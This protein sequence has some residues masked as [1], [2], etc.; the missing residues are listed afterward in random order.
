MKVAFIL[1]VV[2][3]A[4]MGC[5][6]LSVDPLDGDA[7]SEDDTST[8]PHE[9]SGELMLF[10]NARLSDASA[11]WGAHEP[12]DAPGT[13]VGNALYLYDPDRICDDGTNACRVVELGNL[14]LDGTLGAESVRDGSLRKLVIKD[15]AWHAELGLWGVTYDPLN[16]E[17]G[18]G[19]LDVPAWDMPEQLI[20][21][22]RY[23]IPQGAPEHPD[24]DPCYW[25]EA[26]T[27][28]GFVE[29]TLLLG[30]RGAGGKGLDANGRLFR[31]DFD[32]LLEHGNCVDENDPSQDPDYY[33]CVNLCEAWCDFGEK[34][35]VAGDVEVSRDGMRA[36]AWVRS[37]DGDVMEL[38]H[39]ELFHCA[40]PDE[41]DVAEAI[42]DAVFQEGVA[43]G[44]EIDGLARI[45]GVLYGINA[46]GKV[47]E[48]DEEARIVREHDDL[49]PLFP[50]QGLKAR[51]ATRVVVPE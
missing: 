50:A 51:G 14:R 34:L 12:L 21:L 35:G 30:V 22:H 8:G 49:G 9:L 36:E 31:V 48:I 39:N 44:A 45:D 13:Y 24:T 41:G 18:I 47:Y 6:P 7:D 16:D 2:G 26:V 32:A 5:N 28:L 15:L 25:Q 11:N 46:L 4:S 19:S 40:P 10:V 42:P 33:A 37:E 23:V 17:W 20:D 38:D 43:A 1:I 29:D 27:G 3:A